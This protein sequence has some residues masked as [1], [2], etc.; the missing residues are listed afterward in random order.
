M[1][2]VNGSDREHVRRSLSGFN[3]GVTTGVITNTTVNG[4]NTFAT[5]RARV[6]ANVDAES[7]TE[8]NQAGKIL[9]LRA[10]DAGNVLGT[11]TD[12]RLNGLTTVAGVQALYT[13]DDPSLTATY[14]AANLE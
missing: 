11:L 1:A 13:A 3:R 14:S 9:V 12:A 4:A 2:V 10:L 6:A 5:F 7:N 8:E